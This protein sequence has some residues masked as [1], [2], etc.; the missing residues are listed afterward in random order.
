MPFY[1][2]RLVSTSVPFCLPLFV[3]TFV[4][5]R[6][7]VQVPTLYSL[8]KLHSFTMLDSRLLVCV[9][10]LF[11]KSVCISFMIRSFLFLFL[12]FLSVLTTN[13]N[14]GGQIFNLKWKNFELQTVNCLVNRNF[15]IISRSV[16]AQTFFWHIP[17]TCTCQFCLLS[18]VF[19]YSLSLQWFCKIIRIVL[20]VV[21]SYFTF[22]FPP[23]SNQ[24]SEPVAIVSV[25]FM[26]SFKTCIR[27][28]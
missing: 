24:Q 16:D 2:T 12:S 5:T 22:L 14:A 25:W 6:L 13:P 17:F 19:L 20:P 8:L 9:G 26:V 28:Y 27:F 1:I 7:Q 23:C 4:F 15:F 11:K 10:N 3:L 18:F 21:I